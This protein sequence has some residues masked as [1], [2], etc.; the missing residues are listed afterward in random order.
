MGKEL[1]VVCEI[2]RYEL[3]IVNLTSMRSLSN[4]TSV[5]DRG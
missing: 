3:D 2:E 4:G 1:G 5:L